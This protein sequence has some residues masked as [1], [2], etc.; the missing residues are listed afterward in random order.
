MKIEVNIEKKY[1]FIIIGLLVIVASL[2]LGYAYTSGTGGTPS[3][4]G[5]SVDEID[6]SKQIPGNINLSGN[7]STT[8]VCI[9]GTCKTDWS[10]VGNSG[11]VTLSMTGMGT[12][13][14]VDNGAVA[15]CIN[16][17]GTA[18]CNSG[19]Y[20]AG[21]ASASSYVSCGAGQIMTT[22]QIIDT[23]WRDGNHGEAY[24][25]VIKCVTL[26]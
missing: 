18:V 8:G 19:C 15:W 13:E 14:Y 11:G 23:G 3:N 20:N 5:H 16:I 4:M 26:S 24:F 25:Y 1:A 6:W 22:P 2:I 21:C 12:T 10:Q 7:L 17:T 9:N